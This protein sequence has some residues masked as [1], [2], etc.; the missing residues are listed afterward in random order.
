MN[1]LSPGLTMVALA[2]FVL[3]MIGMVLKSRTTA[4]NLK[5]YAVGSLSF[6][7]LMVALALASSLTSAA[8]FI[9]N[10][11]FISLY[12]MGAYLAFGVVM[13]LAIFIALVFLMKRF[14][15]YGVNV[16]SLSI[17]DWVGKRFD[18]SF[19]QK[20]F[21]ALSILLIAFI[22][23]ICVGITKVISKAIDVQE[24]YVLIGLVIVVFTY[25][26]FGGANS[27][28]YTN[29]AQAVVMVIVAGI[30]L[31][32][33]AHT[34]FSGGGED[35]FSQLKGID[36]QL[37]E[38]FNKTSPLFRDFFEVVVCNAVIGIAIVCQPHILT[39]SLMLK[40][41]SE[42]NRFLLYSILLL[43]LFFSVV[44]VGFYARAYFPDLMFEGELLQMD[45]IIPAFVI[46]RFP[47]Y[48]S[49]LLIIGLIA[50]GLS[51]LE[52]LIQSLPTS[53]TNDLFLP[54]TGKDSEHS[55]AMKINR[56][57]TVCIAVVVVFLSYQQLV[58]PNLSVA[59]FAQN[60]VY[61]F[62]SAAFV[63][64]FFGIFTKTKNKIIPTVGTL[65]AL[66]VYYSV[67]YLELTPYMQD[68]SPKN[69]AIASALSLM[70]S[71]AVASVIFFYD[72]IAA[73]KKVV[74]KPQTLGSN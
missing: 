34:I 62:F 59:I 39:K 73:G 8:T 21:G 22:V 35:L 9:I 68:V 33:G 7:P 48:I 64:V 6:S 53:L 44:F 36:P 55:S 66:L 41:D 45:G 4:D 29:S 58:S 15:K 11:G 27:L 72:R 3:L 10:P 32:S 5:S 69:P 49:L 54:L 52:G 1:Q 28:V 26:M 47:G 13:P 12:G 18:S 70:C 16:G 24:L 65:T 61:A 67:Y 30:L 17:A 42:V 71:F 50:A 60:G 40:K 37:V 25:I 63:P 38:P 74:S 56:V 20:L 14:R 2:V 19:L 57:I 51:T 31:Y 23:L 43:I 46:A